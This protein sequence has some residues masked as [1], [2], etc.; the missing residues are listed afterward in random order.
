MIAERLEF[1]TFNSKQTQHV[2]PTT[3]PWPWLVEKVLPATDQLEIWAVGFQYKPKGK[4]RTGFCSY[5]CS[6]GFTR[7][8]T[9]W[10]PG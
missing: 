6:R 9:A 4:D 5:T 10:Y 1:Q 8:H 2:Q 7:R 3:V